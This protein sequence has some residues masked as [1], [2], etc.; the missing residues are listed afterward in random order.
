LAATQRKFSP[1]QKAYLD[2]KRTADGYVS[3]HKLELVSEEPTAVDRTPIENIPS[4]DLKVAN[5]TSVV[6]GTGYDFDFNWLKVP[7]FND[8]GGPVQERGVTH[9]RNLYFLGLHWMHTFKS[10]VLFGV[11]EDAAYLADHLDA[12]E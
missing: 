2:F 5:R 1:R 12:T 8:R 10:G 9:C 6:W 11:G 3:T 7:V 4:L